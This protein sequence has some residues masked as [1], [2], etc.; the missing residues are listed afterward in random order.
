MA[1]SATAKLRRRADRAE[2]VALGMGFLL[3]KLQ[4]RFGDQFGVG[5]EA[6][7]R[8]AIGDYRSLERAKLAREH[9]ATI[10]TES[11]ARAA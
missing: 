2:A 6:R 5:I 7:V 1:E 4:A 9:A 10:N 11:A 3:L 8:Q